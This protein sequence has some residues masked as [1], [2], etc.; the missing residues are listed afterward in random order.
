[1]TDDDARTTWLSQWD[2]A[3]RGL[4]GGCVPENSPA[5]FSAA[6]AGGIGIELDVQI[7]RDHQAMVFH[8]REFDRLTNDTGLLAERDAVEIEDVRFRSDHGARRGE[9]IPSLR[10]TLNQIAGQVPVL[11]EVKSTYGADVV[12][13]CEGVLRALEGYGGHHAV[14]SFDPTVPRWFARQS[15]RTVRGLVVEETNRKNMRGALERRTA[16]WHGRPDFLAYHIGDLPSRFASA[17]R[18]RGL[19]ILT[20]TVR[21]AT[22]RAV[23]MEHADAL[24][25]EVE[26]AE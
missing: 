18:R 26:Q 2:Y 14:M 24:I 21:T 9:R 7:S 1:M 12:P 20:W 11:I 10:R 6:I 13:L 25:A 4:H 17:Q 5:A 15:P 3:H 23:G 16:L 8:D 19:P 22:Q